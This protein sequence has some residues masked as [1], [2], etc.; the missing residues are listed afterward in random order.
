ME[1]FKCRKDILF[2][3][4]LMSMALLNY[5]EAQTNFKQI[6]RKVPGDKATQENLE[7]CGNYLKKKRGA[8]AGPELEIS[9]LENEKGEVSASISGLEHAYFHYIIKLS[10]EGGKLPKKHVFAIVAEVHEL[11]CQEYQG[12][13]LDILRQYFRLRMTL[14][15]IYIEKHGPMTFDKDVKLESVDSIDIVQYCQGSIP[16]YKRLRGK[17]NDIFCKDWEPELLT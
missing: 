6:L 5:K 3:F 2:Y 14:V 16:Q 8:W 13:V 10:K 9:S 11:C 17:D 4:C 7:Q 12:L 1:G 15:K